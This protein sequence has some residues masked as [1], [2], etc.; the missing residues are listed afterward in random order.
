MLK[1]LMRNDLNMRTGKMSA[2]SAHAAMM[3]V[4]ARFQKS[5]NKLYISNEDK[6]IIDQFV[7]NPEID[8]S[9]VESESAIISAFEPEAHH[10]IVDNG[11][12]EF[13]GQKTIT[14]G[15]S[16]LF[17]GYAHEPPCLHDA[18]P[19]GAVS[20]Q[21]FV[22]SKGK[23]VSKEIAC[24][25]SALGCIKQMSGLL[26]DMPDGRS[27]ID[28]DKHT[29]FSTWIASGYG[30]IGL[31]ANDDIEIVRIQKDFERIGISSSTSFHEGQLM[32]AV[33]PIFQNVAAE[34]TGSLKLL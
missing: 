19:L 29:E 21:Y 27:F 22:F 14:C 4:L 9:F 8:F 16:G 10:M 2:Q 26:E 33:G 3:A 20:R 30:K 17:H 28:L 7:R 34:I 12:T 15:S 23:K 25:L 11:L 24:F 1:I 6:V 18:E 13:S 32:L 31:Q 5:G